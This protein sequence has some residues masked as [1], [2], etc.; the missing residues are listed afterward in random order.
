MALIRIPSAV[1]FIYQ[2]LKSFNSW[3]NSL[4]VSAAVRPFRIRFETDATE[5]LTTD[6]DQSKSE[7]YG[8][9]GGIIGFNLS[10]KQVAC[11]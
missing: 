1:S 5:V 4:L 11:A 3:L 2:S 7:S 10:W 8:A 9:P 6:T